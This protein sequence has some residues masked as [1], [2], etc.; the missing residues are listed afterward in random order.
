M[1][2][3]RPRGIGEM[4]ERKMSNMNVKVMVV[5]GLAAMLATVANAAVKVQ[6][7]PNGSYAVAGGIVDAWKVTLAADTAA[8]KVTAFDLAFTG[9]MYQFGQYYPPSIANTTPLLGMAGLPT[10]AEKDSHFLLAAGGLTA[11]IT[12][13]HENNDW[14]YGQPVP[15]EGQGL[16]T[17]LGGISGI[18]LASQSQNLAF[19]NIAI[20]RG[21]PVVLLNGSVAD[22]QGKTAY[23]QGVPI[24]IPEPATM[25]L[26]ALGALGMLRRRRKL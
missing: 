2:A 24:G 15:F 19:A 12:A 9:S 23:Y 6:V 26:L 16:G 4:K 10:P 11:M 25:G 5:I 3:P 1:A 20:L 22:I 21:S 14:R 8:E 13:P 17:V 18:S 7:T